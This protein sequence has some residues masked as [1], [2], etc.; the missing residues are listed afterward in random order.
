MS[1]HKEGQTDVMNVRSLEPCSP[2]LAC[3]GIK[4][5][6]TGHLP[7]PNICPHRHLLPFAGNHYPGHLLI[8][9]S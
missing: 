8:D 4:H 2:S 1:G 6:V 9:Q 7:L 3:R 5:R